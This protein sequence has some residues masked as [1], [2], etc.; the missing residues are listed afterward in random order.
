MNRFLRIALFA[1]LAI[2]AG[3]FFLACLRGFA[4]EPADAQSSVNASTQFT[5]PITGTAS[6]SSVKIIPGAANKFT[7]IT[8]ILQIPVATAVVQYTAGTGTNCGTGTVNLTGSLTF[9]ASQTLNIGDGSSAILV[10]PL[11]FDVCI[12]ISTAAAPGSIAYSQF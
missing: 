4:P 9:A 6:G 11:G 12:T 7:N 10:A 1:A 5:T 8:S 3:V 2:P